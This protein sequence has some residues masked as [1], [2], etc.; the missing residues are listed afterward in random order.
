MHNLIN[1]SVVCLGL[2]T[3][4]LVDSD[5]SQVIGFGF[6][7]TLGTH[8]ATDKMSLQPQCSLHVSCR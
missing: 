4:T 8:M 5:T 7:W 1:F 3:L 6:R 2:L